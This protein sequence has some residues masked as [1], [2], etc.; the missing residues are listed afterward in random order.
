[1]MMRYH[2]GAIFLFAVIAR[3]LRHS[4]STAFE[5]Q[6]PSVCARTTMQAREHHVSRQ[7]DVTWVP[8]TDGPISSCLSLGIMTWTIVRA[9]GSMVRVGQC[10]LDSEDPLTSQW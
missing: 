6:G 7:R 1:M 2:G 3:R 5:I 10:F 4:G 8:F 9:F